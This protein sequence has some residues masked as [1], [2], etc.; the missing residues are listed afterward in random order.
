MTVTRIPLSS[1]HQE[2]RAVQP[3][4]VLTMASIV[5]FHLN[6]ILYRSFHGFGQ[7]KFAYGGLILGL[8]QFALLPQ[9]MLG[10]KVVKISSK[11]INSLH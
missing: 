6:L 8:S 3:Y 2:T 5:S 4:V 7:A 11:I 10:L 9:L 1:L